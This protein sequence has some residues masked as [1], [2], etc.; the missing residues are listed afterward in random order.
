MYTC[1]QL[2]LD[3]N[4]WIDMKRQGLFKIFGLFKVSLK[5]EIFILKYIK[6]IKIH[7]F[8]IVVFFAKSV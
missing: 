4:I 1:M 2:Y 6:I 3:M 8:K 7:I 5:E